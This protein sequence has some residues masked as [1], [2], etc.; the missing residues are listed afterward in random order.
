MLPVGLSLT[1]DEIT[2]GSLPFVSLSRSVYLQD[3]VQPQWNEK[4]NFQVLQSELPTS[5]LVQCYHSHMLGEEFIGMVS[6]DLQVSTACSHEY[7]LECI[8]KTCPSK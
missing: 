8:R 1:A 4:H 7:A 3:S 5:M 2:S 6:V